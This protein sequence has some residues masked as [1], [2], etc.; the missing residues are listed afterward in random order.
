MKFP[1]KLRFR[2]EDPSD[3][4]P[5]CGP[6]SAFLFELPVLS[7]MRPFCGDSLTLSCRWSP[8][9]DLKAA[10]YRAKHFALSGFRSF[11]SA[12]QTAANL[13]PGRKACSCKNGKMAATSGILGFVD[14]GLASRLPRHPQKGAAR[15]ITQPR[16]IRI[17]EGRPRRTCTLA[18]SLLFESPL[19]IRPSRAFEYFVHPFQ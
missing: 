6:R 17:F 12:Q 16:P 5:P 15:S 13:N 14:R 18:F 1:E 9:L 3:P 8:A 7:W 11:T 19:M 10:A 2:E 4:Y